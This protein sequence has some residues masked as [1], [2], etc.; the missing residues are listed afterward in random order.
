[1]TFCYKLFM[2]IRQRPAPSGLVFVCL[3]LLLSVRLLLP[4]RFP[5]QCFFPSAVLL[6]HQKDDHTGRCS[7]GCQHSQKDSVSDG[8]ILPAVIR[9]L[10]RK[11][12]VL[13]RRLLPR[14]LRSRVFQKLLI[15]KLLPGFLRSVLSS[16]RTAH[17]TDFDSSARFD[18]VR[19]NGRSAPRRGRGRSAGRRSG[20]RARGRSRG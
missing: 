18:P 13:R 6:Y 15:L 17:R 14:I 16:G 3:S 8:C 1:M 5:L 19:R 2:N 20:R 11:C 7:S 10:F 4:S 12:P 9:R